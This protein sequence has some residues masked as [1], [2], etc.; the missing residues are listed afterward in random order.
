MAFVNSV[1]PTFT[2]GITQQVECTFTFTKRHYSSGIWRITR[3]SSTPIPEVDITEFLRLE[4]FATDFPPVKGGL[5][6]L[7][8]PVTPDQLN[9]INSSNGTIQVFIGSNSSTPVPVEIFSFVLILQEDVKEYRAK[10]RNVVIDLGERRLMRLRSLSPMYLRY[11][12]SGLEMP[13][14]IQI[15]KSFVCDSLVFVPGSFLLDNVIGN[16]QIV[17]RIYRNRIGEEGKLQTVRKEV[18]L[19]IY[20]QMC[21]TIG[22]IPQSGVVDL[23]LSFS[24]GGFISNGN[25]FPANSLLEFSLLPSIYA[26]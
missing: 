26:Q 21:D 9:L 12:I 7:E 6:T 10:Q 8:T 2:I 17:M 24:T 25:L 1:P 3:N 22:I 15:T 16:S 13:I 11:N 23:F 19:P 5:H 20:S 18:D 4:S 14:G